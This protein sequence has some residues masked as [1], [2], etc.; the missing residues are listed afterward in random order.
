MFDD[1][2]PHADHVFGLDG[3]GTLDVPRASIN[4]HAHQRYGWPQVMMIL[5]LRFWPSAINFPYLPW[6]Q[7]WR[8]YPRNPRCHSRYH[9]WVPVDWW[10]PDGCNLAF[11]DSLACS[12]SPWDPRCHHHYY[13][14]LLDKLGNYGVM[15]PFCSI[16]FSFMIVKSLLS[17]KNRGEIA[18]SLQVFSTEIPSSANSSATSITRR[19]IFHGSYID[20]RS[21]VWFLRHQVEWV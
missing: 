12:W 1:I 6:Y 10:E 16:F 20:I 17:Y 3:T 14:K 15:P 19:S 21:F 13:R 18:G 7:R 11:S 5:I 2:N 4:K 8:Q 9:P